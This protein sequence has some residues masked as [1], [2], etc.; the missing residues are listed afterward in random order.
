MLP[1]VSP[2]TN[3]EVFSRAARPQ[4]NMRTC[5]SVTEPR[6]DQLVKLRQEGVDALGRVDDLDHHGR[7]ARRFDRE[8]AVDVAAQA[9]ARG[10][11]QNRRAGQAGLARALDDGAKKDMAGGAIG[12]ADE[13][14]E[15]HPILRGLHRRLLP[16][17]LFSGGVHL[18]LSRFARLTAG[19]RAHS[20]ALLA[21]KGQSQH[22]RRRSAVPPPCHPHRTPVDCLRL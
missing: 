4:R 10:T 13:C 12:L 22:A 19:E 11:A 18:A 20:L 8:F 6:A 1:G 14:A 2:I 16:N 5:S 3:D 15:K 9:E 7:I 21:L 17:L